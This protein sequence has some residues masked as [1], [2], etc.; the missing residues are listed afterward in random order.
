MMSSS[1]LSSLNGMSVIFRLTTRSATGASRR[2]R[3][4]CLWAN[5]LAPVRCTVWLGRIEVVKDTVLERRG[6]A[7][8]SVPYLAAA[9][10]KLLQNIPI[11]EPIEFPAG[12]DDEGMRQNPVSPTALAA[13]GT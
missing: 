8:P 2:G 3:S 5:R 13:V 12:S 10:D 4:I 7:A 11:A 1:V 6:S 9:K